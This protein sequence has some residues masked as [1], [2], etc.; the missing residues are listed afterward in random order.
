MAE[1]DPAPGTGFKEQASQS[2]RV[3]ELRKHPLISPVECLMRR[4]GEAEIEARMII[5]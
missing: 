5:C 3:N 1:E 4:S 2:Q